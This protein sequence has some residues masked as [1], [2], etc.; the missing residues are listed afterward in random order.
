[1]QGGV[2]PERKGIS[3]QILAG[4]LW[5]KMQLSSGPASATLQLDVRSF[6]AVALD[7]RVGV[8]PRQPPLIHLDA[9][10]PRAPERL[11]SDGQVGPFRPKEPHIS[12]RQTSVWEAKAT[13]GKPGI[14][15]AFG[16]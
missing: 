5:P 14:T 9:P 2:E 1:M 10:R 3:I 11:L 12:S 15:V 4:L 16:P 8:G 7:R 13:G 6:F